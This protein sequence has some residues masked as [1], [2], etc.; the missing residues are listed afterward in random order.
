MNRFKFGG[1]DKK[2]L[3][4]DETIMRM[5]YTHRNLFAQL[6]LALIREGKN[7][8]ALKVLR[9][10]EKS[11]PE[12]NVPNSFVSGSADLARAYALIGCKADAA[13]ILRQVWNNARQYADTMYRRK[14]RASTC[15]RQM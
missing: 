1:L 3:Y 12:Y 7:D 4:I 5:C 13:R 9:K 10:A 2:G 14:A 11:I 15:V 8:K 6:A